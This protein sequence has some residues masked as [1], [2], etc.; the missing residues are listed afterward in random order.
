[1]LAQVIP[2][3]RHWWLPDEASSYASQIDGTFYL[4]L[5]ITSI[6]FALFAITL[7]VFLIRYRY[8]EGR[9]AQFTRGNLRLEIIWTII[10]AVILVFLAFQSE[11]LWSSIKDPSKF[12]K[13]ASVIQIH[14]KQFQWNIAY[15]GPDGIFGTKDDIKTINELYL[16]FGQPVRIDL[17]GQ[18]VIHS[19]FVPEF[20]IKQDAVPGLPTS[21]WIIPTKL[22]A[23]DIACAELCGLGHYSMRGTVYVMPKDSID[24]WL[25]SQSTIKK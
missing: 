16:P 5:W 13:N 2:Q 9:I 4:I 18:D 3:Y 14:P 7:I 15:P 17:E 12:P 6:V 11:A 23:Y 24:H 8:R 21:V 19:F 20:R 1:M 10:P 22:G 25:S